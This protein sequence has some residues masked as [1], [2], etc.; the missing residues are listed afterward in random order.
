MPWYA[1]VALMLLA[2]GWGLWFGALF[3]MVRIQRRIRGVMTT[4]AAKEG[5]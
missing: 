4:M 1:C 5:T 3:V 2:F